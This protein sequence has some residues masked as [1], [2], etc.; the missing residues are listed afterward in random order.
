MIFRLTNANDRDK[1]ISPSL[2]ENDMRNVE[3]TR[4]KFALLI[5]LGYDSISLLP[6]SISGLRAL[7]GCLPVP[8]LRTCYGFL[9][10]CAALDGFDLTKAIRLY[11]QQPA[12]DGYE[13]T[14]LAMYL[15][16][17]PH[18]ISVESLNEA[19]DYEAC[20]GSFHVEE[21]EFCGYSDANISNPDSGDDW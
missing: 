14:A 11:A 9:K 19:D 3:V 2:K 20:T 5:M 17:N 16:M 4:T 13:Y 1:M 15:I 6:N 8:S 21:A 18:L 10:N 7:I 12:L